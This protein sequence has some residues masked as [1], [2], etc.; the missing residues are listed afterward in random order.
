MKRFFRI[1]SYAALALAGIAL[2]HAAPVL[3]V[4]GLG[5]ASGLPGDQVT[6]TVGV[7]NSGAATP[8]D[9]FSGTA[10]FRIDFT[11][12]TTGYRFSVTALGVSPA[13]VVPGST[14][15]AGGGSA[16]YGV[17]SFKLT[18]TL[19]IKTLQA[20]SYQG[21]VTLTGVSQGAIGIGSYGDSTVVLTVT[22]KPDFQITSLGYP[23][24]TSYKGGDVI[25]M[26]MT[27]R[28]NTNGG[29][30]KYSV[31]FVPGDSGGGFPTFFRIQVVL[32][33]NPTFGDADDFQLIFF[34]ISA[35]TLATLI[36]NN[37]SSVL[38]AD[39]ADRTISWNQVLPGNFPGS[40]YVLAKINMLSSSQVIEDDPLP[41]S[42]NGNNVW[43]G[44]SLDPNATLINILPSNFPS[45]ALASHSNNLT[46]SAAGYS[47]NP[48]MSSDGRYVA[49][50]SD[51]TDLVAGDTNN[52]RDIFLFD[53]Q[54]NTTRLVSKSQQGTQGNAASNN[55]ALSANGRWVGF[56]SDATNLI[57]GDTN[58]FADIYAVDSVSGALARISVTSSG[59]QANN[60]SF[61]P[62]IS[63]DGRFIAFES[64]AT[65][66]VPG[67]VRG[68]TINNGGSGYV[69]PPT[70]TITGGGA[71]TNATA[72]ATISG[73][74]VT[75]IT[76]NSGGAGYDG[77][78]VTVTITGGGGTLA[79]ATAL[80]TPVVVVPPGSSHIYLRNRAVIPVLDSAQNLIMDTVGNTETTIV[81]VAP[82]AY[83]YTVAN[84]NSTQAAISWDG[85][86]SNVTVVKG[87][88]GYTSAPTVV[89]SGGGG[90]GAAATAT[91]SAGNVVTGFVVTSAGS[92]YTSV[93]QVTLTG[94]GGTGATAM[95]SSGV[96]VAFASTATNLVAPAPTAGTQ[97]VYVRPVT[98][99]GTTDAAVM[100]STVLVSV[101][102]TTATLGNG[103]S[104]TPSLSADGHYVAFASLATNLVAG[105]TNGVSDIFVYDMTQPAGTPVVVRVSTP[106]PATA[107]AQGTDPM[108]AGF[109]LGSINPTISADG[110]YVAFASLDNNLAAYGDA[111]GRFLSGGTAATAT[112]NVGGGAVTGFNLTAP[113]SGFTGPAPIV[114]IDSKGAG[115][116]AAATISA[117]NIITGFT[118]TN[119][120]DGNYASAPTVTITGGGATTNATATA[121]ISGGFVTALNVVTPGAGYTSQPV[122]TISSGNNAT[123]T[124]TMSVSGLVITGGGAGYTSNP[125]ITITGGGGAGATATATQTGGVLTGLVLTAPGAG[126]TSAPAITIS[127][128]GGTG[129][130]VIASMK[131]AGISLANGGSGYT[132]AP[133]VTILSGGDSNAALDIFVHDRDTAASGTF[134]TNVSTTLVSDNRFGYQTYNVLGAP[135]TAASNIYP[136]ISANGRFVA[137]PS[138]AERTSGLAFGATNQI[139]LDSNSSRDVFIADRRTNTISSGSG[140]TPSVNITG[141]GNGSTLLVNTPTTL[142]A[143]AVAV[144]GV[145][146][147]VQFYVNG[148]AQGS[149]VTVF[150]YTSTW[151]P[152]AVGT[153]TLSAIVTDSFG[154]Q[155]ISS[156]TTVAVS[157]AP[158]VTVT[159]PAN[160]STVQV[161]AVQTLTANA[162]A[163]SPGATIQYV[164]FFVNGL[165]IGSDVTQPPYQVSWTPTAPTVSVPITA[166][167]WDGTNGTTSAAVNVAVDQAPTV[168][169]TTPLTGTVNTPQTI[170]AAPT[171]NGFIRSVQFYAGGTSLGVVTTAPYSVQWT[172]ASAATYNVNAVVTNNLGTVAASNNVSV[173]VSSVPVGTPPVVH[174]TTP[175]D[176][177]VPLP[178]PTYAVNTPTTLVATATSTTST[179]AS[180]QFQVNNVTIGTSTVFPYSVTWTPTTTGTG[181]F[182]LKAVATDAQGNQAASTAITASVTGSP[183]PIVTITAPT[184]GATLPINVATTLTVNA[185]APVGTIKSVQ[186]FD[187]LNGGAAASIG[188]STT[189]P[190]NLSWTPTAAG[191]HA[192]TAQATDSANVTGGTSAAVTAT[193]AAAPTVTIPTP[194]NGA[195][196]RV[197][198]PQTFTANATAVATGAA[199]ANVQFFANGAV[200]GTSTTYPY[201]ITWTPATTGSYT[202]TAVATDSLGNKNTPA[203]ATV[204]VLPSAA[205]PT[206]SFSPALPGSIGVNTT[207][208]L[209]VTATPGAGA[210]IARVDFTA[211]GVVIGTASQ[212]PYTIN[213]TPTNIGSYVVSAVATDNT[214]NTSVP[215]T[216]TVTVNVAPTAVITAPVAGASVTVGVAQTISASASA[217]G[218]AT[219]ASVQFQVNGANQGAAIAGAGPYNVSWTPSP[220]GTYNL[221]AI[222]TDSNGVQTTSAK[223]A[224]TAVAAGG[225]GGGGLLSPTGIAVS[226]SAAFPGDALSVS[227]TVNNTDSSNF[228]G[229]ADFS[230]TF[231]NIVTGGTFTISQAGVSPTSGFI[232]AATVAAPPAAAAPGVGTF[233]FSKTVP[234]QITQAGAYRAD[235]T[236]SNPTTGTLVT[237][238]FGVATTVLTVSGLPDLA[239]TNLTYAASTSYVGGTVIPMS[240][241]YTN[242]DLTLG[243]NGRHNVPYVPNQNGNT[244]NFIRIQVVL[245]AN[246]TFGDADDFQLTVHDIQT[247]VN[248]DDASHTI[249]WNQVLPGNFAGTYYVMAKI[250]SLNTQPQNDPAPLTVNGNNVWGGNTLNPSGTL[251]TL[252]P[253]NFPT[254]YLASHGAGVAISANGYSD[255]P[256]MTTDGRYVAFASD[257]S[258]LVAGDTN[259]ARDVF[260]FD[261]QTGLVH[262][263]SKS[264]QGAQG[265]GASNN[266]AIS[267]ANGRY[268]AFESLANNLDLLHGDTNGFSDIFVVDTI[269]GLISRVSGINAAGG[270]ANNPSFK[271]AIS[272]TGQFVVFQSTATNLAATS[273]TIGRSHIYLYNRDVSNSGV[274]DTAG[275]TSTTMIDVSG[276]GAES[277]G[278]AIQAAI[279]DDGTMVAFASKATNLV[280]PATTGGRQHVYVRNFAAATTTL[281]SVVTGTALEGNADSQTP[282]LSSGGHYVAFASLAS[283]LVTVLSPGGADT[284]G[285]S[286]IFVYDTTQP[287]GTPVV[288]RVSLTA[289]GAQGIDPSLAGFQV[290]SINPTISSNGRYVAF[291]SLDNN[292]TGGDKMGQSQATDANGALDVFVHDR[293]TAASGTFDTGATTTQM[294]TLNKFGYQTLSLLSVPSTAASNI[295][296]VISAN[297]RY[298][299]YPSDAENNA[300][301][302]FGAT[303]LLPLD[304]NGVR[305]VFLYDRSTNA[306]ITAP[307]PPT[308]TIT[309][310]GN[311]TAVLV[312]TAIPITASATTTIGVVSSVQF[313]VNGVSL[314]TTS[315]FPYTQTWTPVAVGNYTLSA[316]VTDSFGNIG[317]SPNISVSVKAAPSVGITG[318]VAG[319]SITVNTPKTVTAT[320]AASNPGGTIASIQFF[321][322]G[323]SLGAPVVAAPYS[324]V[325]TPNT[326]GS[327]VLT[328]IATD[329]LG[330][331]QTSAGV[332]V[333]VAAV[334]GGGGGTPPVVL[335]SS[336]A[337]ANK[338][339]P[340]NKLINL[341]ATATAAN[342]FTVSSVQFYQN[343]VSLGTVT[344][345]PYTAT[346]T[347]SA[348]GAYTFTAVATDSSGNVGTTTPFVVNVAGTAPI[349]GFGLPVPATMPVNISHLF[350]ATASAASGYTVTQVQYFANGVSIGTATTYP[351]ILNWTP[352]AT[353]VYT[354][355]VVASDN[356]GSLSAAAAATVTVSG[357]T[358][359]TIPFTSPNDGA[360]YAL[361]NPIAVSATAALG[362]GLLTGV[363]FFANGVSIG[364][365]STLPF[366][367]TFTPAA[368]GSY[369][370]TAV[371]TDSSG[372]TVASTP[373]TVTVVGATAPT[374]AISSPVNSA[375]LPVNVPQK[376]TVLASS[377]SASLASV[378]LNVNGVSLGI[379]TAFPYIFDW[380]PTSLGNY[381]VIAVATDSQGA[382]TTSV[383]FIYSVAAAAPP[384]VTIGAPVNG[385]SYP[386]GNPVAITAA[387]TSAPG[388]TITSV[389][390][391]ANG[392]SLGTK[393]SSPY[394]L[395]WTPTAVGTY[396]LSAIVTDSS[397]AQAPSP[398][399]SSVSVTIGA[400]AAPVVTLTSPAAPAT[401]ALG[402][403][404][405]LS[406]T[407]SDSDGTVTGVQFFANGLLLTTVT[408]PPYA[409]SW[410][411]QVSGT[412]QITASATDNSGNVTTTPQRAVTI[413]TAVS[414]SV[415]IT[416]PLST[417]VPYPVGNAIPFVVGVTGGNGPITLV[418]FFVNG[419]SIGA[420]SAAPYVVQWTPAAAGTY[421]LLAVATDSAGIST[422]SAQLSVTV[423]ANAPPTVALAS[424][425]VPSANAGALVSL[426]ASASDTDGTIASVV[427]LA[428]GTKVATAF[429]PPYVGTWTPLAG[430]SYTIIAQATDNSGNVTNS[431]PMTVNVFPNVAPTVALTS[432]ASGSTVRVGNGITLIATASDLDGTVAS[433]QF[434]A[435]GIS[436]GTATTPPYKAQWTPAADGIYRLVAVAIDNSGAVTTSDTVLAIASS[437]SGDAISTG[438]YQG[439]GE[440]G[441]FAVITS[442]GKTAAFIAYSTTSGANKTYFY[443]GIPVD[444]SGGYSL[445]DAAGNSKISGSVSD[446]G[447]SG[448]FDGGRL[449]FI[450]VDTRYL[451]SGVAVASGYY[452]G[453]ITGRASSAL[454]AIIGS[455]G[456]IMLYVA[457][458]S[459][460][461]A[462]GGG[463]SGKVGVTGSFSVTTVHGNRFAGTADPSTHLL[464]GTLS[465][466]NA[467]SSAGAFTGAPALLGVSTTNKVSGAGKVV[468]TDIVASNGNV[469]D[470]VL[471][472]GPSAT[473]T[474]D[475]KKITRLSYID[476]TN[477]IVQVEFSGAGALSITLDN[478]S[479]PAV[480]TNYNQ[481]TLYMKGH[482]GIVISGANESTNVSVFSVGRLTAFDPTGAFNAAL[483]IT[484]ANNPANNGNPIFQGHPVGS[485]D[486]V[487]DIGYLAILSINGKFGGVRTANASYFATTGIAGIL[488]P[489]VQF[490]GPVYVGDINAS[491]TASP[492]LLLGS[493]DDVRI[494]G[495]DLLQANNKAVQVSGMTQLKFTSGTTSQG[496][497]LPAQT[498]KSRLEQNGADVTAQVVVNPNP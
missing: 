322:N 285:V 208:A 201:S 340:V 117:G 473:I 325:W 264:Q 387:T 369:V 85:K 158:S 59:D 261:S 289:A 303:N 453:S 207:Q 457:D 351:Y 397:G 308:V 27:F 18:T 170:T 437:A 406:A 72:T 5:S 213:W 221:T 22:G 188:T 56:A 141:P 94:G 203:T 368:A 217:A 300:G 172:P 284:N 231:T 182:I 14:T 191:S 164:R 267:S 166:F 341:T 61:K 249:N 410:V 298:V 88:S 390:F 471:L 79:S 427:F 258:N 334:G 63:Q 129:A 39:G 449:T 50:A 398:A 372:N 297:G 125:T 441:N 482:A 481:S 114:R 408:S 434:F 423:A 237:P 438:T 320:A 220:A 142:S 446:T 436:V 375:S 147:S 339:A 17:G 344:T 214:G 379:K 461:D 44:N 391:F 269:T 187:S 104:Q 73:G 381:R 150:P 416:N 254:A 313:F 306:S 335:L 432:P 319:S 282:S 400:N 317:V 198:V 67:V 371:G 271:P 194:A 402:Q 405:L 415:S 362:S 307:T 404:V 93:P 459:F 484:A 409:I 358:A 98:F 138:D 64:T 443:S 193:V 498:D 299:A 290:G 86:M 83:P 96:K 180:V 275:N 29:D 262:L 417:N 333:T 153:Y 9:D 149:A 411:P 176:A 263:L 202:L 440:T 197:N 43:S 75:G 278:D 132:S 252:L 485:Y 226:P 157:A 160:G 412:Y 51:A 137:F 451:S 232:A 479:G 185:T 403:G 10:N 3:N 16:V 305:D 394:T 199:I 195:T 106:D 316:I 127:G 144:V 361:G 332:A 424:N 448:S 235:V 364:S 184:A 266:P 55:P 107:L 183:A 181:T 286:D 229:K 295:Y 154:N 283:N 49:F 385:A 209:A 124:A 159:G 363:Q 54:T 148:A 36:G 328:A 123:A 272:Q 301:L 346:F 34:D 470:Q 255:N 108:A 377:S 204:T 65:N 13:N 265:N 279:S 66:L 496:N 287:V 367:I 450:G 469:Y 145:V 245:S 489:G 465:G 60:P 352:T 70:V 331:Q 177:A 396:A 139:I 348:A 475:P 280:A 294:V 30:G 429:A 257:A 366:G 224:V 330:T 356:F 218:G 395:I 100:G 490:T 354:I 426:S 215:A 42:I 71:T 425:I 343:G 99:P 8:A 135:S 476:L 487:A 7:S 155:G 80:V 212:F 89:I 4:T 112:A 239:I 378:E 414:T 315:V 444:V 309:S 190:F 103:N 468:G 277:N 210:T 91:V 131:V 2:A 118:V 200:L 435:N 68:F 133:N 136:V 296:P 383:P 259:G 413:S 338:A 463:L 77:S 494:T 236:M 311:A 62:A 238:I 474:A 171:P 84:G 260:Y 386:V 19:P 486:G 115:A 314:G 25:P 178:T 120:G 20:G 216:A 302:A 233:T 206:V 497:V 234:T 419:L 222:V 456:S 23:A 15:P 350:T 225:G 37:G 134:D 359:P 140:N 111:V 483:P 321:A 491:A 488:A 304:N 121:T 192:L 102:N 454:S 327:F 110:R 28:N 211:N 165:Q 97:H 169:I 230:V 493:A 428:N 250:D 467:G 480:A 373:V 21:T 130:T 492:M 167:A 175:N 179:I 122:I 318:P 389:Q 477:D 241:T 48:S 355:T 323:I 421:S 336:D 466:T 337:P 31:P 126:Y 1:L 78:A 128:G 101:A 95:A 442:V 270:Q 40:Y 143:S 276:A 329:N 240:L 162:F 310:P 345:P 384:T 90:S 35:S 274:F 256:S 433:V 472:Q 186:F 223:V 401:Y 464:T 11:D 45:T 32:S 376:I 52:A 253:S 57:F 347:P 46:T 242:H 189:A 163:N 12:I 81:D 439:T 219:V 41:N 113:G 312:N 291:A 382:K 69:T 244:A 374:V 365:A 478:A 422:N 82:G 288:M 26:T 326:T 281:V 357:G 168:T 430:G 445:T 76:L 273:T 393:T 353:G 495:G 360:S 105:D 53:S 38:N 205:V 268:V 293:D 455:D 152:T 247:V 292:L 47:D 58:G 74:A 388:V 173:V 92:G 452:T 146:S 243:G 460:N 116:T 6:F 174:L 342:G 447:T 151:T 248:A 87:G 458:G 109:Q 462:G 24:G 251:I 227:I 407:A 156:N 380:T 228:T 196:V 420:K 431:A 33:A 392:T 246:P 119:G 418:Q 370:F 161:N 349:V 399:S 324:I